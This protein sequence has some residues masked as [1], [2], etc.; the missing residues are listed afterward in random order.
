[1]K[2]PVVECMTPAEYL[3]LK[4]ELHAVSY[5]T[6]KDF[7]PNPW[8]YRRGIPPRESK[9]LSAGTLLD[10]LLLSPETAL[11]RYVVSPYD[12]YRSNEAKAWRDDV[13]AS[14]KEP[15][16]QAD[17]DAAREL[18][19]RQSGALKDYTQAPL[20]GAKRHVGVFVTFPGTQQ[21]V[22][23]HLDI[24]PTLDG[25]YGGWLFDVKSTSTID[26]EKY[27]KFEISRWRYHWQAALY[28]DVYNAAT[29]EQRMRFGHIV[30]ESEPPHENGIIELDESF[31]DR[32]RNGYSAALSR[33]IE[34]QRENKWP[35]PYDNG[36]VLAVAPA[37]LEE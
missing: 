17:Y 7:A 4:R 23:C 14:G 25:D 8:R 33:Y 36:P 30:I 13:I 10:T 27:G 21:V 32:G 35:S 2:L 37:W 26:P 12:A 18:V 34:C 16:K 15:I 24:V 11:D 6:L 20:E 31:L 28:R 5:S 19:C 1:M 29:G 22:A 9:A 3:A